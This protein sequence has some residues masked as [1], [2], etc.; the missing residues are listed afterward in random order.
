MRK[1]LEVWQEITIEF[2]GRVISGSYCE[3]NGIVTVTALGSRKSMELGATPANSLA[4][5]LLR[6]LVAQHRKS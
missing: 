3:S 2:N 1:S 6:E 5:I 4:R